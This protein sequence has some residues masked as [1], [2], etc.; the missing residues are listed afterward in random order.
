LRNT[1]GNYYCTP[2]CFLFFVGR[3]IARSD[4]PELPQTVKQLLVERVKESVGANGDA[5]ALAMRIPSCRTLGVR[6][7]VDVRCCPAVQG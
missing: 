2:E 6:D 5:M 7:E 4:S 3:L 1:R